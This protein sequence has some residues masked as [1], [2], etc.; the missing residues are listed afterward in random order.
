LVRRPE[1]AQVVGVDQT[2][3][4]DQPANRRPGPARPEPGEELLRTLLR[5]CRVATGDLGDGL[6]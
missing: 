1:S 3:Q 4:D 5:I 2:V 6:V